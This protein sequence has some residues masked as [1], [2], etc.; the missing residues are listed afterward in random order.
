MAKI[1]SRLEL[2]TDNTQFGIIRKGLSTFER[3]AHNAPEYIHAKTNI[4]AASGWIMVQLG[5]KGHNYAA[6]K[7][8]N[9]KHVFYSTGGGSIV[10]SSGT[11]VGSGN[12]LEYANT[13]KAS[14]N[15]ITV[16]AKLKDV[17]RGDI[18]FTVDAITANP[19]GYRFDIEILDWT[20]T[21]SNSGAF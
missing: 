13:Y 20:M 1:D 10:A 12:A 21:N 6:G 5:F 4:T 15:Y 11:E 8:I 3:S 16:C 19:T 2:I 17:A 9:Y 7:M 18:Y 14:D